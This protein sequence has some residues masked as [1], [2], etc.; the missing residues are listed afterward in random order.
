MSKLKKQLIELYG[1]TNIRGEAVKCLMTTKTGAEGLDLKN[2]RNVHISEPYWQP[3]LIEQV[4]GRAV[5][6]GSHLALPLE[7]RN[8]RIFIYMSTIPKNMYT[9]IGPVSVRQ[10]VARFNDGLNMRGQV[11]TSD[12]ALYI[13]SE[14]KKAITAELLNMIKDT[15]FDCNLNYANNKRQHKS[16]V[17]MD[18]E[19][20]DRNEYLFTPHLEDTMDIINVKQDYYVATKYT[21]FRYAGRDYYFNTEPT[22]DGNYFIYDESIIEKTRTP[23]PIGKMVI[24]KE[25][26]YLFIK[27]KVNLFLKSQI[28]KLK[29]LVKIIIKQKRIKQNN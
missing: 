1:E 29:N 5:R 21:K 8:V 3:V 11:V 13:T 28:A 25:N 6:K 15:A 7:E 14:R 20:E 22:S 2:I 4:I 23:K 9:S 10:D 26:K 24:H 19:T 12:E 18:Y 27:R 16:I 17:C